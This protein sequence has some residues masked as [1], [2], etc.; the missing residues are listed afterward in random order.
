MYVGPG[1]PDLSDTGRSVTGAQPSGLEQ[2]CMRRLTFLA[3]AAASAAL[4]AGCSI[5][6]SQQSPTMPTGTLSGVVTGP[7]GPV[8]NAAI[9]VT[10]SDA[11]SHGGLSNA[12]G[13]YSIT[14]IPAG[15]ATYSVRAAGFAEVDGSIV[16]AADPG[17]NRQDVNL[18]PQ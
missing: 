4:F 7:G 12:D 2:R 1:E 10:A 11:T 14:G 8:S 16:I 9:S 3:S 17:P 6:K 18:N 13:Y 5:I 15:P